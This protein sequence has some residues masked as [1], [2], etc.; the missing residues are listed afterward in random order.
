MGCNFTI[1][2]LVGTRR[3]CTWAFLWSLTAV[4]CCVAGVGVIFLPRHIARLHAVP[5]VAVV[6]CRICDAGQIAVMLVR[7]NMRGEER[8]QHRLVVHDLRR[9]PS[10][11]V[12]IELPVEPACFAASSQHRRLF[13]ADAIEGGIHAF[14]LS[15]IVHLRGCL[16]RHVQG[17][18]HALACSP[19]ERTVVSLGSQEIYA[20]DPDH[21]MLR[22]C[23]CDER[24]ECMVVLPDSQSMLCYTETTRSGRLI[25]IDLQTGSTLQLVRPDVERIKRLTASPDGHFVAAA[26]GVGRRVLLLEREP[27][28]RLWRDHFFAELPT[29]SVD[30][31]PAF[32]P[33][34]DLVVLGHADGRRLVVWDLAR[35]VPVWE[36]GDAS[37]PALWGST[38]LDQDTLLSWSKDGS[39]SIWDLQEG[40][41]LRRS[42]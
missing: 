7:E 22:W 9:N 2:H 30:V 15:D 18:P 16:G 20:W 29:G 24:P 6:D 42:R 35:A 41:A 8:V 25:E 37:E 12:D 3:Q 1:L 39:I 38:F 28:G 4:A 33:R 21:W 17:V 5:E 23:R 32:S 36:I 27:G 10:A 11:R 26:V 40:D 13:V 34:S 19:D 14:D 31:I